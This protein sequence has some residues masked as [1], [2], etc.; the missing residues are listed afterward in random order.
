MQLA[1]RKSDAYRHVFETAVND[2]SR[3]AFVGV[4]T[5][6]RDDTCGSFGSMWECH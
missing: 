3:K 1:Y 5:M 6:R 4:A 2:S